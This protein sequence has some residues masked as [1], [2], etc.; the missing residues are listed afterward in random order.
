MAEVMDR[1]VLVNKEY[2]VGGLEYVTVQR[3]DT[4]ADVART[5]PPPRPVV[6]R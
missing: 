1:E 5:P 4:K 3:S 6:T 2:R